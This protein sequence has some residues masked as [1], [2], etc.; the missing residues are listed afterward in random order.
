MQ[1]S[2]FPFFLFDTDWMGREVY[3]GDPK[4]KS[5]EVQKYDQG[6][7]EGAFG[8]LLNSVRT[9]NCASVVFLPFEI[10]HS[11]FKLQ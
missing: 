1:L 5:S 7:R 2:W 10:C 11:L 4:G 8:L 3:H 9:Q 6:V